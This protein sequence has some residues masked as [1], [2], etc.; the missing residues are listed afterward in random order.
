MLKFKG[1]N[2]ANAM[3]EHYEESIIGKFTSIILAVKAHFRYNPKHKI[4]TLKSESL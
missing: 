2:K 1:I 3:S 4:Q